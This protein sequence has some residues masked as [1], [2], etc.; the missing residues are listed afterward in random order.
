MLR[1]GILQDTFGM[2]SFFWPIGLR[3][4]GRMLCVLPEM[5]KYNM[6]TIK[7]EKG[8]AEPLPL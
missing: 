7:E 6:L 2:L 8:R 1:N 3:I 5:G 4:N